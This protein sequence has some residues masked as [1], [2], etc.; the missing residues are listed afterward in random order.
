MEAPAG[1]AVA[2]GQGLAL[3]LEAALGALAPRFAL[4]YWS[5]PRSLTG[6]YTLFNSGSILASAILRPSLQLPHHVEI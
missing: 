4:K 6:V 3:R 1:S 2:A 5:V